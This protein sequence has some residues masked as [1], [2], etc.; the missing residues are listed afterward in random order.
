VY[1]Y[2]L[3]VNYYMHSGDTRKFTKYTLTVHCYNG[4]ASKC[5]KYKFSNYGY[6]GEACKFM[7][8]FVLIT[9][10]FYVSQLLCQFDTRLCTLFQTFTECT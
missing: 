4:D 5:I 1:K 9:L 10:T 2:K 6:S 3:I 8:V 7:F